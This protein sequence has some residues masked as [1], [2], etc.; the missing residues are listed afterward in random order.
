MADLRFVIKTR[1]FPLRLNAVEDKIRL[2]K[3]Q[4]RLFVLSFY[5]VLQP[6]LD[7]VLGVSPGIEISKALFR[8]KYR[9]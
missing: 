2:I 4:K 5:E 9:I 6:A 7:S 3:G 8:N 1:D